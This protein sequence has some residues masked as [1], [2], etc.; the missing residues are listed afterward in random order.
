M[1][2][3]RRR[4]RWDVGHGWAASQEWGALLPIDV[5]PEGTA[6]RWRPSSPLVECE[7]SSNGPEQLSVTW[8]G[9]WSLVVQ[10]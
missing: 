7:D 10:V 6:F 4:R 8:I 1:A 9:E 5:R 2:G 3:P